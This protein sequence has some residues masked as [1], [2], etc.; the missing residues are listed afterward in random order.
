[1][2]KDNQAT[3]YYYLDL[4][5]LLHAAVH[6]LDHEPEEI[7]PHWKRISKEEYDEFCETMTDIPNAD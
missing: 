3:Y 5:H 6:R 7:P 2:N 1:M 4:G